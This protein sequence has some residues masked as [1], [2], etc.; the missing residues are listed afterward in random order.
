MSLTEQFNIGARIDI[1]QA[2]TS[3]SLSQTSAAA[4]TTQDG[5]TIDRQESGRRQYYSCKIA[6]VGSFVAASSGRTATMGINLQHS[7]DGTSWDTY[8]TGVAATFGSTNGTTHYQEVQTSANLVGARRYLRVQIPAPTFSDCSSGQGVFSG[9]G[10]LV[11]GGAD[12]LP[13][14]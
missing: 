11:F 3:L 12:T 8:T 9:M 13:A 5:L 2:T 7:S 1:V 6:F 14:Q 10:V 4:V